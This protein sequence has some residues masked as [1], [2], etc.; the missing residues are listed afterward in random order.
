MTTNKYSLKARSYYKR[1]FSDVINSHIP[2]YYVLE[3]NKEF[4]DKVDVFDLVINQQLLFADNLSSVIQVPSGLQFS[5]LNKL[6]NISVFFDKKNDFSNIDKYEFE[7]SI[8]YDLGKSF[9]DF[10]TSGQFKTYLENILI[11]FLRSTWGGRSNNVDEYLS[12]LGWFYILSTSSIS[13][14]IQPSSLVVEALTE[15]LYFDEKLTL[16]D[17]IN[18]LTEYLWRNNLGF[19]PTEFLPG[20]TTYT[21]GTQQLEKLKTINKI[22][23]STDYLN[24]SDTFVKDRFE[25]F[26]MLEEVYETS[27]NNGAFWRLIRAFSFAFADMQSE[28]NQIEAFYDLQDCPDELL[29]ELA[30]LI[31]WRLVGY[32]KNKWRLQLA[33]A[34]SIY[35]RAGTK[36]S[37][38][39]VLN[40]SFS[41][42]GI[43]LE[44]K[45]E[46]LWE[47]YLPFLIY[48]ALATESHVYKDYT[49]YTEEIAENLGIEVFD[50]DNFDNNIRLGVD[51]ILLTLFDKFP[52][53]FRLGGKP[54]PI[55][56][57]DF[58]FN[59]RDRNYPIPPFEEIPY[60]VA[61]EVNDD[62]L[63]ELADTLVC[64]GVRQ[65][66]ALQL[67]N[68]VRENT[69]A[70]DN[71]A[72]DTDITTENSW[73]IF[74]RELKTPPN[75]SEV[76]NLLDKDKSIYLSL[77][78][79]KSSHFSLQF[80]GGSFKFN[81]VR[82]TADSK[83][84]IIQAS[85]LAKEYSPAHAIPIVNA[86]LGDSSDYGDTN[87]DEIY[88]EYSFDV[89]NYANSNFENKSIDILEG[90]LEF[91]G[92]GRNRL[93]SIYSPSGKPD[94]PLF[95]PTFNT[96]RQIIAERRSLRRRNFRGAL[97]LEGYYDRTGF[98][99]PV[100]RQM[101]IQE[102][103]G[104]AQGAEED[105]KLVVRG[106]IPSSLQF[107]TSSTSCSGL[108]PSSLPSIYRICSPQ[109]KS[110]FYGY[111]LSSTFKTR[112][113]TDRVR[114]KSVIIAI[115]QSNMD[116]GFAAYDTAESIAKYDRFL[117]GKNKNFKIWQPN[118]LTASAGAW[119]VCDPAILANNASRYYLYED[120]AGRFPPVSFGLQ[121][122][123]DM[124]MD[125]TEKLI[126][127]DE[128][129][130]YVIKNAK[131]GT[132]MVSGLND[133][134][135]RPTKALS[136]TDKSTS[137][138]N[139]QGSGLYTTLVRDVSAA[140]EN[141]N[142]QEF[143]SGYEIKAVLLIQGEFDSYHFSANVDNL[144]NPVAAYWSSNFVNLYDDFQKDLKDML[145]NPSLPDIP[146]LVG[147]THIEMQREPPGNQNE[148]IEA[149]YYVTG[150][151]QQQEAAAND[152]TRNVHLIDMDNVGLDKF[153]DNSQ[154]HFTAEGLDII[155][156]RFFEKYKEIYQ[157]INWS[158][159]YTDRGQL[160]PFMYVI[161]KIEQMKLE[162]NALDNAL[163]NSADYMRKSLWLNVSASE[164]NKAKSCA[165]TSLTSLDG[166]YNYSFGR[167]IHKLYNTYKS[168]FN[169]HPLIGER[170]SKNTSHI[171]NHCYGTILNN[172]DFETRGT[173][174]AEFYTSASDEVKTLNFRS[175][176]FHPSYYQDYDT[177]AVTSS[178]SLVAKTTNKI[179]T[180]ELVNSSIINGVDLVQTSG[181][182][183]NNSFTIYD[184]VRR[185][186]NNYI[187][188]NALVK[189][190][191]IDGLPR[192]RFHVKGI[193]DADQQQLGEF[194]TANF[195]TPNHEFK[196]TI[197][198]LASVN[199]GTQLTDA[200]I[201]VWIH[202]KKQSDGA[203]YHFTNEGKW[204]PYY[205]NQLTI[206]K[207]LKELTHS[208]SFDLAGITRADDIGVVGSQ[209]RVFRCL[210]PFD[211]EAEDEEIFNDSTVLFNKEYFSNIEFNFN[212]IIN[213]KSQIR[214]STH[215]LGQE[216]IIEIF[217]LPSRDNVNQFVLLNDI[218]LR[219]ETLWNYTF[220]ETGG[221]LLRP[222][223]QKRCNPTKIPIAEEDIRIILRGFAEFSG[224]ARSQSFLSREDSLSQSFHGA[225]G[226]SRLNYRYH[227][228][229]YSTNTN[230]VNQYT[231]IDFT[232]AGPEDFWEP[233]NN[234]PNDGG[235][236]DGLSNFG[237]Q[238]EEIETFPLEGPTN[239]PFGI[240]FG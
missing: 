231:F 162:A 69:I 200:K 201:G 15:K 4:G 141:L 152:P 165:I 73:L 186:R 68:Y 80:S 219:D 188:N 151:R 218:T 58:T 189:L 66:F 177:L 158:D 75:W 166:Y 217:M 226:G 205:D 26:S 209:A 190:R 23:Y 168:V 127:Y 211:L 43:D 107:A 169:Y 2:R 204:V 6:D 183:F 46:E 179:V 89:R 82:Y 137:V 93:A 81:K 207:I 121:R 202:T 91:S 114:P 14:G 124:L 216:Y 115:G 164:A 3:D 106:Y 146:W 230:A 94:T 224:K 9:E 196:L 1:N 170:D 71:L 206:S 156:S 140:I 63:L 240:W 86:Y 227:P 126:D 147:R 172:S 48:Y 208:A 116:G 101:K 221:E 184:Y 193:P 238:L 129:E 90:L 187:K 98:N 5:G 234:P 64:F 160:D 239:L 11:P 210:K 119:Q 96:A 182:S 16:A 109:H 42:G 199:N 173:Y 22:L 47:S 44:A 154:V 167:N 117:F 51:K 144:G 55:N 139:V 161:Y 34:L 84:A 145:G 198:G 99:P 138:Y 104:G 77:W 181:T 78:N 39:A 135:E 150:V 155:G 149:P 148:Y 120:P 105:S 62:F 136:W 133:T 176:P 28:V 20:Q 97:N 225:N 18:I 222:L 192:L 33:N 132:A 74:T 19:I 163:K 125:F 180:M 87:S 27:V 112:D 110:P 70:D 191:S 49:T 95:G 175:Y 37:I 235:G 40:S 61:S 79:G 118:S 236:N 31:G 7:K 103:P 203:S 21:S 174:G 102:L 153:K 185:S 25:D 88:S 178:P 60:Y 13:G 38:Q 41:D 85:R 237:E 24:K 213:C 32:D 52:G 229:F 113:A 8:L 159:L 45:L 143:Q 54:F 100:F 134:E 108:L 122:H 12:N 111:Y 50:Y 59:Y 35:K 36:Q 56:S 195:L 233:L 131:N 57:E 214:E 83:Y 10:T 215:N 130:V 171:L 67:I 123:H 223:Y 76:V 29:P 142:S 92:L 194:R 72:D 157:K 232:D 17:G 197:N 128:Q 220:I 30:F 228:S 65:E 212:T 53:L